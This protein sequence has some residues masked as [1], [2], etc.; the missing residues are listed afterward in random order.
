M[1]V[2]R[3]RPLAFP[4]FKVFL[5]AILRL[6][7][8][9]EVKGQENL[10]LAGQRAV[11]VVNHVS[12]LD[13]VLMVAFLPGQPVFPVNSYTA[14][15]WWVRPALHFARTY[16]IDPL[17]P[18]ATK[19]L[20]GLVRDNNTCVIFPE[21]RLT[22]TGGLM[23]IYE[24]PGLIADRADAVLVP[25]R[26]DGAQFTPFSH[27]KGKLRLRWF[28]RITITILPPCRMELPPEIRGRERRRRAGLA[29]YD[30]MSDMMFETAHHQRTLFRALLDARRANGGRWPIIEDVARQPMNYSR[31]LT[32]VLVLG[33][34]LSRMIPEGESGPV[35]ILLPNVAAA[36]VAFFGL[37]AYGRI[38][39]M[40]NFSAGPDSVLAACKAARITTVLTSRRFIEQGRLQKL[41][42]ALA[43]HHKIIYLEDVR[44]ALGIGD[45]LRGLLTLPFAGRVESR[46]GRKP[47][48]IA[49]ILFTSGSEGTPKGVALS[50]RNLL[51]N[52]DQLAARI[53]FSRQDSVF[54]ALPVFHSFGLIA[55]LLPV[56][57]GI[58][59]FLYPSP[60]HYRIVPELAYDTGATVVF[61]TDTFLAG[62]ARAGSPYDFYNVRYAVAG[63]E[64]LRDS[65]RQSWIEKFG[66][67]ILEGYGAT[68]TAPVIA[69]NTP[70]HYKIGTV[71]RLLPAI[72][73]QLEPVEGIAEGGRLMVRGP[74]VMR[75]Y[76]RVEAPGVLEPP[77]GGWYDTGDIVT[78]D[79][80]GFVSISG[81]AKRFA[82]IAGEMISLGKVE[83]EIAALYPDG[84]HAVLAAPDERKGEQILLATDQ[85]GIERGELQA[86]LRERG[87]P[88]LAMPRT[89][90][91][92]EKL[93]MLGSGKIDYPAVDK[94]VAQEQ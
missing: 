31:L 37:H 83:A 72:E 1:P 27:L 47:D 21:G 86:R 89:I 76:Y 82:K 90:R 6:L 63:G 30:V 48:D 3:P 94:L 11:V 16:K 43:E 23:K 10:G 36:P 40:L 55:M 51:A 44:E 9:V 62:Y 34:R 33:R 74:N 35:G 39:A 75:G 7:Y 28:P 68:E 64:K 60:L 45:K 42:D 70:M 29:L 38:P 87:L 22:V 17:N 54:N 49:V 58:R 59:T 57:N 53:A 61:G 69:I 12:F 2:Q 91:H 18:M 19:S 73:H 79:A 81:R 88:E 67:R 77:P 50:H 71:G 46:T 20:I 78:V 15:R 65:T 26:I 8:R 24:G 80:T 56:F 92:F 4:G 66:L 85:A 84:H 13:P 52:C 25:V 5:A 32:G 93:P 14:D 41:T